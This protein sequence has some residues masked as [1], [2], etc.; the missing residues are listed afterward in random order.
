MV[1]YDRVMYYKA[2]LRSDYKYL[3]IYYVPKIQVK[4]Q[5]GCAWVMGIAIKR[6]KANAGKIILYNNYRYMKFGIELGSMIN[7]LP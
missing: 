1:Y 7:R 3:A 2:A 5:V 6:G 4:I